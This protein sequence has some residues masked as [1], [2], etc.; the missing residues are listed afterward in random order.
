MGNIPF[1]PVYRTRLG[2]AQKYNVNYLANLPQSDFF[3]F[4][5]RN[6]TLSFIYVLFKK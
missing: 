2:G 3:G 6:F 1:Q 5:L 4:V